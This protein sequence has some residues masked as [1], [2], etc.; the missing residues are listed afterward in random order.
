M[1]D[2]SRKPPG[3]ASPSTAEPNTTGPDTTGPD[4]TGQDTAAGP[5]APGPLDALTDVAGLRVGHAQVPGEGR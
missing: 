1:T 2:E 3:P 5:D 4:T